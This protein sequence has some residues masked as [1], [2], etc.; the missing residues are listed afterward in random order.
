MIVNPPP[1]SVFLWM[2]RARA[3]VVLGLVSCATATPWTV[4]NGERDAFRDGDRRALR[5][6]PIGGNRKGSN[7]A[8]ALAGGRDFDTGT[9][10]IDLKGNGDGQA[11]FLGVAFAVADAQRYEAVYFRPFNFRAAD[12]EHRGHAVQYIA[13]PE[14][15]WERLRAA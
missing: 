2:M 12:A 11:S 4:I 15:T 8:L 3:L 1:V 9:I 5:L 7:V 14:H 10:E 13:W 6:A